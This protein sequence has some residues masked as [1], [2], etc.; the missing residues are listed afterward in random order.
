MRSF[1]TYKKMIQINSIIKKNSIFFYIK[2]PTLQ[3]I[4]SLLNDR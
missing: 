1:L 3:K 4:R 2:F